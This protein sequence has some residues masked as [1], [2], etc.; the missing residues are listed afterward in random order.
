M[1][2]DLITH[3]TKRANT[4]NNA[5]WVNDNRLLLEITRCIENKCVNNCTIIDLG[6]GTGVV[7]QHILNHFNCALNIIAYDISPAMLNKITNPTIKK[8]VGSIDQL[9]FDNDTADI[10]IARQSLHYVEHLDLAIDEIRRVLKP[11]GVFVLSQ[12]M[13]LEGKSKSFWI[14]M[15]KIRQPLRRNF[16]SLEEWISYLKKRK[17]SLRSSTTIILRYSIESWANN[18]YPERNE[19]SDYGSIISEASEDYIKD[20]D[21]VQTDY[22]TWINANFVTLSGMFVKD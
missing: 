15:M 4:Y 14:K 18:Y 22:T 2:S 8:I 17:F 3:F 19:K 10:I 13:P 5:S 21:V 11:D 12:I 20:Y 9:P 1:Y 6:A 16:F 7:A